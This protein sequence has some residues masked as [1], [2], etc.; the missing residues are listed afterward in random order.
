MDCLL[1]EKNF[2]IKDF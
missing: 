2:M 1:G